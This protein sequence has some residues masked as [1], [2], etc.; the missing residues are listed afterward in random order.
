MLFAGFSTEIAKK[1][2]PEGELT[3]LSWTVLEAD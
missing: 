2:A 1:K 3:P